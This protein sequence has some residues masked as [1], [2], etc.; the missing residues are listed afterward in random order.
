MRARVSYVFQKH[1]AASLSAVAR[2]REWDAK[3][4]HESAPRTWH[5]RFW[6]YCCGR[7]APVVPTSVLLYRQLF[8]NV[9]RSMHTTYK[10]LCPPLEKARSLEAEGRGAKRCGA[11][12]PDVCMANEQ[13]L[14]SCTHTENILWVHTGR[15]AVSGSYNSQLQ[16]YVALQETS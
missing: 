14:F 13:I 4:Y 7:R 10:G 2:L 11:Q 15:I 1:K 16:K 5:R 12:R 8:K 3:Q 9:L 6:H